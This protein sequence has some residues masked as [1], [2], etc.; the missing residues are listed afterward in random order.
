MNADL[1]FTSLNLFEKVAHVVSVGKTSLKETKNRCNKIWK[2]KIANFK[3]NLQIQ[4]NDFIMNW[5]SGNF[6]DCVMSIY[7]LM[8]KK[9]QSKRLWIL[10]IKSRNKKGAVNNVQGSRYHNQWLL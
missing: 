5:F 3:S 9:T 1:K 2:L 4:L 8:E 6:L 7:S 10:H